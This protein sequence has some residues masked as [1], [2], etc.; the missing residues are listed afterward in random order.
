MP[1]SAAPTPPRATIA[2]D[3]IGDAELQQLDAFWRAAN[4]LAGAM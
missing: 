4:Y 3:A 2:I 1:A